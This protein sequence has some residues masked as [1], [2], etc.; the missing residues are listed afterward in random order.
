M[1]QVITG[2]FFLRTEHLG[3]SKA[4]LFV[5]CMAVLAFNILS[6]LKAAL[7]AAHGTGKTRQVSPTSTSSRRCKAPS[8]A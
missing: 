6:M 3:Y 5:F 8:E 2:V 1:F 4:A 7:K